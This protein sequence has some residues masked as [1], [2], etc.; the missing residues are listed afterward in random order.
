MVGSPTTEFTSTLLRHAELS[1]SC[2][3]PCGLFTEDSKH[4][5]LTAQPPSVRSMLGSPLPITFCVARS[6]ALSL[7]NRQKGYKRTFRV[8]CGCNPILCRD[9]FF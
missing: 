8:F 2:Q 9:L 7:S 3:V 4:T 5:C 6:H 1:T